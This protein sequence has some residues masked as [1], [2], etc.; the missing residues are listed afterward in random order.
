MVVDYIVKPSLIGD[1][2]AALQKAIAAIVAGHDT[3]AK[4]LAGELAGYPRAVRDAIAYINDHYQEPFTM[5]DLSKVCYFSP[6]Y[7]GVL[8][9]KHTGQGI[10]EYVRNLRIDEAKRLLQNGQAKAYEVAL[11]VGYSDYELFRRVF[12]KMVGVNPNLYKNSC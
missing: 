4:R 3:P 11:Q 9:K 1:I 10:P 8:F 2:L 12:K 6:N 5:E 7:L